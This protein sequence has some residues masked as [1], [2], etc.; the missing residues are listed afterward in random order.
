MAS[1]TRICLKCNVP[2]PGRVLIDRSSIFSV[3][4]RERERERPAR[5]VETEPKNH[6]TST[7]TSHK[8]TWHLALALVLKNGRALHFFGVMVMVQ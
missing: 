6:T 3:V 2:V 8:R 4:R 7:H 5:E 1:R